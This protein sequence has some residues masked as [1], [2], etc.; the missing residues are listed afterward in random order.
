MTYDEYANISLLQQSLTSIDF[1]DSPEDGDPTI[2]PQFTGGDPQLY[3][4]E[5]TGRAGESLPSAAA[6][7]NGNF[8]TLVPYLT[9]YRS[10]ISDNIGKRALYYDIP[11]GE[12][13]SNVQSGMC[14]YQHNGKY[15]P[16]S[17]SILN[18]SDT[19][20][21]GLY[22]S[23]LNIHRIYTHG[24]IENVG[25]VEPGKT[26]GLDNNTITVPR[27]LAVSYNYLNSRDIIPIFRAITTTDCIL[28]PSKIIEG[29]VYPYQP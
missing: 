26:Y 17:V 14:V 4:Q 9:A 6:K 25:T 10:Y 22:I 29:P 18:S 7:I 8:A 16:Y 27:P 1:G 13:D 28:I 3:P 2:L 5:F 21:A 23:M 24:Y 12:L 20:H 19:Y 11:P 15:H